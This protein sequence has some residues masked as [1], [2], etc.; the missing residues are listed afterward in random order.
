[1]HT[2]SAQPQRIVYLLDNIDKNTVLIG[3][4]L[5]LENRD[6]NLNCKQINYIH[7]SKGVGGAKVFNR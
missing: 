3:D 2:N 6:N 1:M 5:N 7:D 4:R